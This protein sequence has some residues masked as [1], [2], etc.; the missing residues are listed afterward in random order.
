MISSSRHS[1]I[2]NNYLKKSDELLLLPISRQIGMTSTQFHEN[3]SI[4]LEVEIA[5]GRGD[6]HSH[7]YTHTKYRDLKCLFSHKKTRPKKN[8]FTCRF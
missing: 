2:Q 1:I 6:T 4:G 5:G 7:I 8:T 3:W